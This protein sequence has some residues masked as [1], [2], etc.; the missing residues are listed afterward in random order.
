[1]SML[2]HYSFT[3]PRTAVLIFPCEANFPIHTTL[4]FH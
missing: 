2:L 1:M 4:Y 3:Y